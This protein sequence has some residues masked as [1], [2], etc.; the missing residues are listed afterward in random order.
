MRHSRHSKPDTHPDFEIK[1]TARTLNTLRL[2][3][4]YRILPLNWMHA[5]E[6]GGS[7]AGFRNLCTRLWHAGLLS[8]KTHNGRTNNNETQSYMRTVAGDRFLADCGFSTLPHDTHHDAHQALVDLAEAQI[9]LGARASAIAYHSWL[10]ILS[11]PKTPKLPD[12]PFRFAVGDSALIPDGRPFYLKGEHGAILFLREL[13]R[14]TEASDTI[15]YKLRQYRTI[16]DRIRERYGF[17]SLMLLFITTNAT[18]QDNLLRWI[19]QEFVGGCKWVLTGTLEDHVRTCRTT[20][21]I[22][23]ALFDT[24]FKRAGHRPFL[25]K[26]LSEV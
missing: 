19:G 15:L 23:T 17:R 6:G 3:D 26:S 18:R 2:F 8:R 25:L 4:R 24:P 1:T 16:E 20:L 21:P 12:K 11:H 9:E 22:S 14:N 10:D 5:L 13:D 7:Y